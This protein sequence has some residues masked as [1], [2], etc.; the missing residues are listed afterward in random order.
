VKRWQQIEEIFHEALQRDPAERESYVREACNGDSDLHREVASLLANHKPA[1]DSK[2]WA[3][4]AAEELIADRVSLHSGQRLGPYR[5]DSFL[6]AGGMGAVYRATDTR[7]HRQVAIKVSTARFSERF[8]KEARVIASLN[9]PNICQLY[10]VGPNYLVMEFV[11][12][13]PLKR[14]L[15]VEKAVEYA[16]QILD[17]LDAAH[18]KGITHRDLKPANILMTK[19]GIKLLDF[20][21]AKQSA[22]LKETDATQALTQQGQI[23]GTLQ[24]MSPEQ[25]QGKEADARSDL[26]SFGCVLYEMLSGERAFE[27]QSA[28]SV[29]AAILEREPAPLNL[30]PPLERVVRKCLAKDPDQRFQTARDLKTALTWALEQA[31]VPTANRRGWIAA[32]AAVVIIAAIGGWTTANVRHQGPDARVLR[33]QIDPPTG[34]QFFLGTGTMSSGGFAI[35]PDGKNAA[36]VAFVKGKIGLWVRPLDGIAE[37][38]LPGT[39]DAGSPFWSPDSKSIAFF[40]GRRRLFRV[41]LQGGVP[42]PICDSTYSVPIAEGSWG[43]DGY[44]LFSTRAGIFRVSASGGTPSRV[45]APDASGSELSYRWPQALPGGRF[46]FWIQHSKRESTGIYAASLAKPA[47]HVR[48]L[49]VENHAVYAAESHAIY[50][51]GVAGK[52]YLIWLR[53]ATLVAQDFNPATLEFAGA[54]QPIAEGFNLSLERPMYF[55]AS[56]NGLLLYNAFGTVTEFGWFDRTG[57]LLRKLGEPIEGVLGFRLSPDERQVAV[58]R[59]TAGFEDLWLMNAQSGVA[60]RFTVSTAHSDHPVWSPDGRTILFTNTGSKSVLRK[61]ANGIADERV[62][63]QRPSRAIPCDWSGDGHWVLTGEIAPDTKADLWK[64]AVTPDGKMQEGSAPS[65]YLRTP[66]NEFSGR[67]SPEPSPHWVAF[68][69]DETGQMEVYIDSFP[70]P[71]GKKRISTAG[72]FFPEWAARSRELFYMSLDN[73]LMSVSL[74]LG[75]GTVEVSAPRELFQLPILGL[76]PAGSPYEV[77]RDGQRFLALTSPAASPQSLTLIVNWPALLKKGAAAP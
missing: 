30:A 3:A 68:M 54:P 37:R 7:L 24:Y 59:G 74:R 65:P 43:S 46:L 23:V 22:S 67:F 38:L 51:P 73:K 53:G 57:K 42:V 56:A 16:G 35:S 5:I 9:H 77:S 25:L 4:A 41:D 21:L 52:G 17:A 45:T 26:F 13:E 66:S 20:G 14:P 27:G 61:A 39:E 34:G 60:S 19:Q 70:E 72:G 2:P 31:I 36:Y 6:A 44:I 50:A 49:T 29:I 62:L 28:A 33:L 10:H 47:E 71:H 8:E 32:G 1:S 63:V 76:I 11:E 55:A 48:L 58:Q 12:G 15:P 18:W 69:S 75:G 64:I 40:V